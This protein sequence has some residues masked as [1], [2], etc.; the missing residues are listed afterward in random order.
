MS[1]RAGERARQTGGFVCESCHGKVHVTKGDRIPRCPRCGNDTF[2][3]RRNE[4]AHHRGTS[5]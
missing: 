3:E 4:P 5:S 2:G 1:A